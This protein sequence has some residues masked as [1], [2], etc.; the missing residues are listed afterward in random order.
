MQYLWLVVIPKVIKPGP[1]R[2]IGPVKP[3][4]GPPSG[5]IGAQKRSAREPEKNR[6]N[7]ENPEKTG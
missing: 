2:S 4:T 6:G 1:G 7:R 5:P 3:G